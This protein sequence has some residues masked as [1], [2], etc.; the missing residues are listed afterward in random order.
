MNPK[1]NP[2]EAHH[3]ALN[4]L[5]LES[6]GISSTEIIDFSSNINP[7]GP[8][9]I[10]LDAIK[11]ADVSAYPDRDALQLRRALAALHNVEITHILAGNGASELIWQTCFALL[12]P[13]DE[14]LILGPTFGE[15]A[16]CA[17]LMDANVTLLSVEPKTQNYDQIHAKIVHLKPSMVFICNPNNPTGDLFQKNELLKL[18]VRH[19]NTKFVIDEAYIDFVPQAEPLETGEFPNLIILRS[20]TKY[21]ALA[22]IRLGYVLAAPGIIK[23]LEGVRP[24]WNVNS[25]AQAAGVAAIQNKDKVD[26]TL[27]ALLEIKNDLVKE[28]AEIGL[29]PEKS[30][31]H[32]FL[33]KV[34][35]ASDFRKQLLHEHHIQVRDCTSFGLPKHIRISTRLPEE[36]ELLVRSIKLMLHS[37]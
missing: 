12:T 18:V 6:I 33:L 34:G 22:G 21:Y 36:N 2:C 29:S 8:I 25:L 14:V 28:L 7:Y 17:H 30:S 15:Y 27:P 24:A 23:Q 13:G 20:M 1:I 5:E 32:Y 9:Q 11:N 3:G 10:I 26:K 16:R 19:R 4:Y 31:T 37:T 35:E